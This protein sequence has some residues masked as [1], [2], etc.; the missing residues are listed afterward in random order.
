MLTLGVFGGKY[1]TDCQ[2]EFPSIWFEDAKLNELK[3]DI[4]LNY[5]SVDASQSLKQW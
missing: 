4:S 2:Q 1:L 3:K 5:F